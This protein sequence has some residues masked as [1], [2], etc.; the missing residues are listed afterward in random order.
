MIFLLHFTLNWVCGLSK[1]SSRMRRV[2]KFTY[3]E[4]RFLLAL[5]IYVFVPSPWFAG[6]V[7]QRTGDHDESWDEN[8]GV[9]K[10]RKILKTLLFLFCLLKNYEKYLKTLKKWR[11]LQTSQHPTPCQ[12]KHKPLDLF[13]NSNSHR[14]CMFFLYLF[15]HILREQTNEGNNIMIHLNV[16][17]IWSAG[18]SVWSLPCSPL[19]M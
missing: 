17:K 5:V 10:W 18:L 9:G 11:K 13:N 19:C 4:W 14:W 3:V 6:I 12:I 16:I 2:E 8:R 15:I 1:W 7:E